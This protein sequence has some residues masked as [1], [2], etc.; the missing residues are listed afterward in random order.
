MM[1]IMHYLGILLLPEVLKNNSTKCEGKGEMIVVVEVVVGVVD[2]VGAS[3]RLS[4]TRKKEFKHQRSFIS[5]AH[6]Q[7]HHP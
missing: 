2:V 5:S 3:I 4:L 6:V 7:K 1:S